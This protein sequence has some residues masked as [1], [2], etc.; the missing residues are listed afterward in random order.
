MRPKEGPAERFSSNGMGPIATSFFVFF[1]CFVVSLAPRTGDHVGEQPGCRARR[2]YLT[3]LLHAVGKG[4][5]P[6]GNMQ[7]RGGIGQD[8]ME[9]RPLV[10]R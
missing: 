6:A 8:D 7:G 2:H 5:G 3:R 9:R 4:S 10:P 1:V